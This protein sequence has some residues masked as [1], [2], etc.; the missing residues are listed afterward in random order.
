MGLEKKVLVVTKLDSSKTWFFKKSLKKPPSLVNQSK[1]EKGMGNREDQCSHTAR[2]IPHKEGLYW[3]PVCTKPV[4]SSLTKFFNCMCLL[5]TK[6]ITVFLSNSTVLHMD[7]SKVSEASRGHLKRAVIFRSC[8]RHKYA[9][10]PILLQPWAAG[11]IRMKWVLLWVRALSSSGTRRIS[12]VTLLVAKKHVEVPPCC[13]G[14][15][16]S[17][18]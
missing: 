4:L 3:R 6:V 7:V 14:S 1:D 11:L 16:L 9:P 13:T 18:I 8:Y 10:I 5:P 15:T 12:S 17:W 2:A